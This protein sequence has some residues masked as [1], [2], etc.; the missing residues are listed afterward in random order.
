M[1]YN[2]I[3]RLF[4]ATLHV[5][6]TFCQSGGILLDTRGFSIY[7]KSNIPRQVGLAGSSA[8]IIA[9]L[10]SMIEFY[11]LEISANQKVSLALSAE[12]D[13]LGIAAGYQDRVVQIFNGLV[14]MDF[15]KELMVS[16]GYGEYKLLP[17]TCLPRLW[18]GKTKRS[19][20]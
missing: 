15:A 13:Q 10:Q 2:G 7:A 12:Q 8:L 17:A 14:Y 16:R 4:L 9:F 1:G 20:L 5:L 18:I 19:H 11:K 3:H 6:V